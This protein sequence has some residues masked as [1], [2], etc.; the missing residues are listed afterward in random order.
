VHIFLEPEKFPKDGDILAGKAWVAN[1]KVIKD[2]AEPFIR[3]M[4]GLDAD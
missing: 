2:E 4:L 1:G 3:K